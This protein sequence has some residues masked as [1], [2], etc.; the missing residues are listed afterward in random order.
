MMKSSRLN[1]LSLGTCTWLQRAPFYQRRDWS[2]SFENPFPRAWYNHWVLSLKLYDGSRVFILCGGRGGL[3]RLYLFATP[4][5][6]TSTR[7]SR[8]CRLDLNVANVWFIVYL[9]VKWLS[10]LCVLF[11]LY[12]QKSLP[13]MACSDFTNSLGLNVWAAFTFPSTGACCS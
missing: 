8:T 2:F 3:F 6:P 13:F 9:M 1:P 4:P 12:Q 7:P 10:S 5:K 11:I